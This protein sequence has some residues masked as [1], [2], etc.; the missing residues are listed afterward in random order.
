MQCV[1]FDSRKHHTWALV[2]DEAR[3]VM[4]EQWID[5]VR[6]ASRGFLKEF[7]SGLQLP[8]RQSGTGTGSPTRSKR[9]RW[10]RGWPTLARRS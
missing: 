3:K 2:Q 7:E 9:L 6:G 8:L 4:R 10:F 1:A 5:H